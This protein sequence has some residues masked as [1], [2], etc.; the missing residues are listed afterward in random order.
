MAIATKPKMTS[1][2]QS[3]TR[4][5]TRDKINQVTTITSNKD[6][7]DVVEDED[8]DEDGEQE[9]P[10]AVVET[11]KPKITLTKEQI[12]ALFKDYDKLEDEQVKAK[13][14]VEELARHKSDKVKE[15]I[16]KTGQKTWRRNSVVLTIVARGNTQNN[17]KTYFFKGP[18]ATDVQDI[19]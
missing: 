4:P 2:A 18:R 9:E 3:S 7:E 6:I 10:E 11:E 16:K 5:A 19:D 8:E 1:S 12:S 17:E 15:I 13:A 14:R